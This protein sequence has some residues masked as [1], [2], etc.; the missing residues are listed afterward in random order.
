MKHFGFKVEKKE[1]LSSFLQKNLPQAMNCEI[2]NSKIRR[3][4]IAGK[5]YVNTYLC[6]NPNY[7][8]K[9]NSYV[10]CEI[11]E[12][13]LF[14]EKKAD[15]IDYKLVDSDV[16]YQD[17]YII[18]VN[19]PS[20]F[21]TERTIVEDRNCMHQV[22]IDYLWKQNPSLRNPPYVGIMHR[23]DKQ[24][25]GV[26]LFTKSRLVNADISSQFSNHTIIKKYRAVCQNLSHK[27]IQNNFTVEKFMGRISNK[28]SAC[29]M[30]S[31]SKEKGG[32]YS[33][34]DFYISSQK[35]DLLY[36]DCILHTGRTHQI[37]Y[38]LSSCNLPIVGDFLYG[39][40]K[41]FDKLNNRIMLHSC[42]L[43]FFH[44]ILKEEIEIQAPLPDYFDASSCKNS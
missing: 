17:E 24:T 2:S 20:F 34:T 9:L 14:Y 30:G 38:H 29:K 39:A 11:D 40:T 15:D 36:I 42:S 7:D 1:K 6:R 25:S 31:V 32:Q 16:L 41:G 8:L 44:P 33:C 28:S 18:V 35:E 5:V 43:K 27:K 19:K 13:K 22:V 10:Y 26:L 23:L 37:R 12:E 21:P 4:I 3:L